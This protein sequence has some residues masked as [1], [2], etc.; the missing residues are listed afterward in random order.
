MLHTRRHYTRHRR[1][2]P[3]GPALAHPPGATTG[4]TAGARAKGGMGTGLCA[5]GRTLASGGDD[6]Q[7]RLWDTA[8]GREKAA[9]TGHH[10]LVTSLAFSP[11]CRTLASGSF[12]VSRP[13]VAWDVEQ[14]TRLVEPVAPTRK[15]FAVALSPDGSVLAAAGDDMMARLWDVKNGMLIRTIGAHSK[16]IFSLVF[17]PDGRTLAS[18]GGDHRIALTDTSTGRSRTIKAPDQCFALAFSPDGSRLY[19]AHHGGSIAAWNVARWEPV[20][21]LPG[22]NTDVRSLAVSPDGTSLASG[23]DDRTVRV[24]DTVTSH[25][26]LCLTDC[27]A[28]VNAVA[29]SPDGNTLAAADHSGAITI[30]HA[31]RFPK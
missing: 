19:S 28:R 2:G 17:S 18:G 12:D 9:L 11:D 21:S 25:E 5:D 14:G 8:T 1:W 31:G 20:A 16:T 15:V 23:G 6:H 7:V 3:H 29:F 4:D 22:H 13:L 24:W 10:S 26:L 30:W 27:K